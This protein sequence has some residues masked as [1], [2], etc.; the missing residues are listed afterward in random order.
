MADTAATITAAVSERV[1]DPNNTAHAASDIRTLLTHVQ[2]IVNT[3]TSAV[4]ASATLAA[5]DTIQTVLNLPTIDKVLTI[6]LDDIDLPLIPWQSL[7]HH[8]PSWLEQ[9]GAA[10]QYWAPIGRRLFALVPN[11]GATTSVVAVGPK[12]TT[13][14]TSGSVAFELTTQHMTAVI[15]LTEQLL[16]L[17][18]RLFTSA[19][20]AQARQAIISRDGNVQQ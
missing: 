1:R 16:L 9:T 5:T 11:F 20:A 3:N 6:R 19:A 4:L 14:F 13:A 8:D 12:V 15:G 18:Q 10:I 7:R 2:R 17:R